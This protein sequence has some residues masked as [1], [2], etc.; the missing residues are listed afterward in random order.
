MGITR[1]LVAVSVAGVAVLGIAASSASAATVKLNKA[2]YINH[3]QPFLNKTLKTK[4]F[5]YEGEHPLW[6]FSHNAKM[7]VT[8]SGYPADSKVT[9][10]AHVNTVGAED[11]TVTGRTDGT[12]AFRIVMSDPDSG[13][14]IPGPND[15]RFTLTALVGSTRKTIH[16]RYAQGQ[17]DLAPGRL[18]GQLAPRFVFVGLRPGPVWGHFLRP[19]WSLI[20]SERYGVAKG[21]C[22]IVDVTLPKAWPSYTDHLRSFIVQ[23]DNSRHFSLHTRPV[24]RQERVRDSG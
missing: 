15:T 16:G 6:Q 5:K 19:D 10:T 7:V 14:D 17:M 24:I 12:G 18:H 13:F 11:E 9:L 21:P 4:Y 23:W 20:G 2:C 1:K 8:G 3:D 22:G